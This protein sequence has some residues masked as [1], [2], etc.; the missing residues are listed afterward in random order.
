MWICLYKK[1]QFLKV[2]FL[3]DSILKLKREIKNLA[4]IGNE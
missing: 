2:K 1:G 4:I 3:P